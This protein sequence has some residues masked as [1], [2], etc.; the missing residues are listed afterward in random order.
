MGLAPFLVFFTAYN[1]NH[2]TSYQRLIY[3]IFKLT[4]AM[5]PI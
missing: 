5:P 2:V 3:T 1:A 4:K